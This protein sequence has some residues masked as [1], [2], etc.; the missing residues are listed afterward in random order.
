[1]NEILLTLNIIN[2]KI[3]RFKRDFH[4][5]I[6]YFLFAQLCSSKFLNTAREINKYKKKTNE[7]Y[8]NYIISSKIIDDINMI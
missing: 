2:N 3:D 6:V 8:I 4:K 7:E 1:M 5:S